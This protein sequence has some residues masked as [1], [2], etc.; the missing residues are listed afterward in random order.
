VEHLIDPGQWAISLQNKLQAFPLT[1]AKLRNGLA[2][3]TVP[4]S[5][6]ATPL[7]LAGQIF[8][9]STNIL[10]ILRT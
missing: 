5:I 4:L 2:W 10:V 9:R 7:A 1:R 3:Y 6:L 8:G